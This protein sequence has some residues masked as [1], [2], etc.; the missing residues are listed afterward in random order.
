MAPFLFLYRLLENTWASV[1]G[2]AGVFLSEHWVRGCHQRIARQ[3]STSG[4]YSH[5]S[6]HLTKL[7]WF[8]NVGGI[9]STQRKPTQENY[10]Y[11]KAGAPDTNPE[12]Q[13]KHMA[14]IITK[15]ILNTWI[16]DDLAQ[17]IIVAVKKK[18]SFPKISSYCRIDT[19]IY[20]LH[21]N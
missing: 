10:T 2:W 15:K 17:T 5:L 11:L 14:L 9:Q 19:D 16:I 6:L 20:R 3:I 21:D 13:K 4:S 8:W 7:A 1:C 12:S 18:E